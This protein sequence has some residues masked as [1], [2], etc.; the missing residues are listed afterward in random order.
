MELTPLRDNPALGRDDDRNNDFEFGDDRFQRKCPYAAHIRKVYPRDDVAE[1]EARGI[2]S[3][4]PV[5]R[6]APRS[7]QVKRRLGTAGD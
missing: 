7:C 4:A 6:L 3:F 5:S 2:A 1:A